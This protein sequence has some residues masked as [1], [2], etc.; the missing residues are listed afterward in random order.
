MVVTTMTDNGHH[1]DVGYFQNDR[2][3][4]VCAFPERSGRRET[5]KTGLAR[6]FRKGFGAQYFWR[7]AK[8]TPSHRSR[9]WRVSTKKPFIAQ[10]SN[11]SVNQTHW[12]WVHWRVVWLLEGRCE[13]SIP[14][15]LWWCS[16]DAGWSREH[17]LEF[18]WFVVLL[19]LRRWQ[20]DTV[21]CWHL[22]QHIADRSLT[23]YTVSQLKQHNVT[24][25]F[26]TAVKKITDKEIHLRFVWNT[27]NYH[28]L[29]ESWPLYAS[30]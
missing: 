5:D 21:T 15:H 22:H 30:Y 16:S 9:W 23:D 29:F 11:A 27:I 1:L 10:T 19:T 26:G 17:R 25:Y 20:I 3:R 13:E 7:R 6:L 24:C 12:N 8:E 2:S 28:Q 18:I 14:W 4:R